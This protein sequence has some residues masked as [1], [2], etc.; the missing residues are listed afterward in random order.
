MRKLLIPLL[1]AIAFPT[2]VSATNYIE[3]EAIANA[4]DRFTEGKGL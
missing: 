1:S 4:L 2:A 3:C